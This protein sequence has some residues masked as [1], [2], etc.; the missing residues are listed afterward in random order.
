MHRAPLLVFAA[1]LLLLAAAP[2]ARAFDTLEEIACVCAQDAINTGDYVS[3]IAQFSRR[4]VAK[5]AISQAQR[6]E[7][8]SRA[9]GVDFDALSAD[10]PAGGDGEGDGRLVSGWGVSLETDSPFYQASPFTGRAP[11]ARAMLRQWNFTESGAYQVTQNDAQPECQYSVLVRDRLGRAVRREFVTCGATFMDR[12]LRAGSSALAAF[13]VP[14]EAL[15]SEAGQPDGSPLAPGIYR[16]EATWSR[17]GPQQAPRA[18]TE[19][20]LPLAGVAVRI[21]ERARPDRS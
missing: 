5:E 15:S 19:G 9:A 3:C 11:P 10:C 12:D 18:A 1:L 2:G 6:S 14:F 8:V 16:I 13:E 21:V 20:G 7:A 17:Q 4:L